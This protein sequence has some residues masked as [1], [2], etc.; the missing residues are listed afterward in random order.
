MLDISDAVL[1]YKRDFEGQISTN[2]GEDQLLFDR[3]EAGHAI[4]KSPYEIAGKASQAAIGV[5][6][7]MGSAVSETNF[8]KVGVDG[9]R[10][11]LLKEVISEVSSTL[12]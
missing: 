6:L 4:Q 5:A 12:E 1:A 10:V 3:S 9:M 2:I 7:A 11:D 8:V